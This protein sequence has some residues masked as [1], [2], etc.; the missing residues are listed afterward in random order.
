MGSHCS[1][2]VQSCCVVWR[3]CTEHRMQKEAMQA[4]G[5]ALG[6]G[7]A[8]AEASTKALL[9]IQGQLS[10]G[11]LLANRCCTQCSSLEG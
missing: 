2:L 5:A 6:E 8:V 11:C 3:N 9:C 10:T 7:A 1:L 4:I